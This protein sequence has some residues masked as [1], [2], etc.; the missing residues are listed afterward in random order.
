MFTF[1]FFEDVERDDE[2][3]IYTNRHATQ[4]GFF[5]K[6]GLEKDAATFSNI[7]NDF[8]YL[9]AIDSVEGR[10]S[11]RFMFTMERKVFDIYIYV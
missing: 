8:R 7:G 6:N 11:K 4:E 9:D 3:N 5:T 10:P 1:L 2:G